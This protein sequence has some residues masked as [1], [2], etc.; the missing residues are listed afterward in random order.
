M[1]EYMRSLQKQFTRP[2]KR[3]EL[4]RK[5]ETLENELRIQLNKPQRRVLTGLINLEDELRINAARSTAASA[6][7]VCR[8]GFT[9]NCPAGAEARRIRPLYRK[10][11][12]TRDRLYK[13]DP[14]ELLGGQVFASMA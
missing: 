1:Y 5:A 6:V 7:T 13:A 10:E 11:T 9:K 2:L 14:R 4:E 3:E 8:L 12:Q